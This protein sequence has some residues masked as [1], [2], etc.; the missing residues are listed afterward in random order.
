MKIITNFSL[1]ILTFL[2]LT[3]HVEY[4]TLGSDSCQNFQNVP[5]LPQ[6]AKHYLSLSKDV[7]LNSILSH[8]HPTKI[9]I[10]SSLRTTLVPP[11]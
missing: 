7:T 8:M 9:L 3:N 10:I 11:K 4:V 5:H 6:T 1:K 2:P